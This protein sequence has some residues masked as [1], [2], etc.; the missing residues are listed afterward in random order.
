M[1]FVKQGSKI[2]AYNSFFIQNETDALYYILNLIGNFND[3]LKTEVLLLGKVNRA[4]SLIYMLKN[5]FEKIRF[6]EYASDYN[7]SYLLMN[8]SQHRYVELF[9]LL[10]CE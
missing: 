8:E 5:Y 7:I 3:N 6:A 9:E 2:E 1:L 4:D 10:L